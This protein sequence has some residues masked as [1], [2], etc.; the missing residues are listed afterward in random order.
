[1]GHSK[2]QKNALDE[3][4]LR[5]NLLSHSMP[6]AKDITKLRLLG[7]R[8]SRIGRLGALKNAHDEGNLLVG[9]I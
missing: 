7:L 2:I 9:T 1:M 6:V 5:W 8:S 4:N 3:G